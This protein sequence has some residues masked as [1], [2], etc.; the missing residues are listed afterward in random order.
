MNYKPISP[1]LRTLKRIENLLEFVQDKPEIYGGEI[2]NYFLNVENIK[3]TRVLF[4]RRVAVEAGFLNQ[5]FIPFMG[6]HCK[7][8]ITERGRRFLG[9]IEARGYHTAWSF[10]R[11][12]KG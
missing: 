2:T 8:K 9:L 3:Q 7:Y 10:M 1:T 5:R 6:T 11:N 12:N 4:F